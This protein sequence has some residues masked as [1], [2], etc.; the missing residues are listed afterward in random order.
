MTTP[1]ALP[2][3]FHEATQAVLI[4]APVGVPAFISVADHSGVTIASVYAFESENDASTDLDTTLRAL[5]EV[6]QLMPGTVDPGDIL[7]VTMPD[8]DIAYLLDVNDRSVVGTALGPEPDDDP[9]IRDE[10]VGGLQAIAKA[11]ADS[12]HRPRTP[13]A[14]PVL[15]RI[16][17]DVRPS[18]SPLPPPPSPGGYRQTR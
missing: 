12:R 14:F 9:Q 11:M 5:A 15:D 8:A 10:I 7:A 3:R 4:S 1:A 17:P 13:G 2:E 16:N 6:E 18:S